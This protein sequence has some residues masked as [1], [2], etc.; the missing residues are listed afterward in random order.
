[1]KII[2]KK[3]LANVPYIQSGSDKSILIK[4]K[5]SIFFQFET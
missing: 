5:K 4:E 2:K 1:M 3:L